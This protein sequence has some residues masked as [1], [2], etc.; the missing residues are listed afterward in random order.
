MH[1]LLLFSLVTGAQSHNYGWWHIHFPP[2]PPPAP[3]SPPPAPF[4]PPSPQPPSPSLPPAAIAVATPPGLIFITV[5]TGIFGVFLSVVW[6]LDKL[7]HN[8]AEGDGW[9]PFGFQFPREWVLV[10]IGYW[11]M[12]V[13][14]IFIFPVIMARLPG[15]GVGEDARPTQR[16]FPHTYPLSDA[17][18]SSTQ[19]PTHPSHPSPGGSSSSAGGAVETII[20]LGPFL[21][22]VLMPGF[23]YRTHR[24]N[25]KVVPGD[26]PKTPELDP[27]AKTIIFSMKMKLGDKLIILFV[28][29][30]FGLI[31]K[32]LWLV[33]TVTFGAVNFEGFWFP[34]PFFNFWEVCL[35]TG[36]SHPVAY[37][38]AALTPLFL[39][40]YVAVQAA[41]KG[42]SNQWLQ[43]PDPSLTR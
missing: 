33:K 27:D 16:R 31:A 36:L 35:H 32:V 22:C 7:K 42:V 12:L 29:L 39:L 19:C 34:A 41:D 14:T 40:P 10:W 23:W 17:R 5:V 2:R 8:K 43:D 20:A 6:V 30:V 38:P 11:F 13:F 25:A 15:F 1:K 4:P 9:G 24:R 3:P 26:P 18:P 28:G 37:N 21:H